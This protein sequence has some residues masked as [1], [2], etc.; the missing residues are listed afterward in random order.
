M[1]VYSYAILIIKYNN[2]LLIIFEINRLFLSF[3]ISQNK[4]FPFLKLRTKHDII[5][6]FK[7]NLSKY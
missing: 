4:I 2:Y 1:I 7:V 5:Y 3:D 6:I